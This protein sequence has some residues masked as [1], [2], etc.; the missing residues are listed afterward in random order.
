MLYQ[1]REKGPKPIHE[2]KSKKYRAGKEGKGK[3]KGK[4]GKAVEDQLA[5]LQT[6]VREQQQQLKELMREHQQQRQ[7]QQ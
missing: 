5:A 6:T 4:K 2:P 1:V 3:G 7:Q